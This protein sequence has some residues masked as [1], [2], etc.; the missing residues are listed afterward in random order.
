MIPCAQTK[1]ESVQVHIHALGSQ[2]EIYSDQASRGRRSSPSS[3]RKAEQQRP[4]RTVEQRRV[5]IPET[6]VGLAP[7]ARHDEKLQRSS[8]TLARP[9]RQTMG[10]DLPSLIRS[11]FWV[12]VVEC[13]LMH[14]S[15]SRAMSIVQDSHQ[16]ACY[17]KGLDLWFRP[18]AEIAP[19]RESVSCA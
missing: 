19:P 11:F 8:T 14:T 3:I 12:E 1:Q 17:R 16:T 9:M 7:D 18:L 13:R 2:A 10:A 15:T 5:I 4:K 6:G